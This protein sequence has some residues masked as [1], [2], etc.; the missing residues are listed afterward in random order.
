MKAESSSLLLVALCRNFKLIYLIEFNLVKS[1][2]WTSFYNKK[3]LKSI[4]MSRQ[5]QLDALIHANEILL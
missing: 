1:A 2:H 5:L 3:V 4:R